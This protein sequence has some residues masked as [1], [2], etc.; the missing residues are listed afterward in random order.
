MYLVINILFLL[1]KNV[2]QWSHEKE[3]FYLKRHKLNSYLLSWTHYVPF[4]EKN[5]CLYCLIKLGLHNVILVTD[6]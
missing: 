6:K 5:T 1:L 3:H 4:S 2:T